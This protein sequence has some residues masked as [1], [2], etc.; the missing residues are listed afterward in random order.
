MTG[1]ANAIL[2]GASTL[3]RKAIRSPNY[4]TG[5]AGWSIN[6]DGSAE[7]NN[8]TIRG[9]L[10]VVTNNQGVFVYAGPPALGNLIVSIANAAGTDAQ[11]NTY[12]AG[13]EAQNGGIIEVTA[14]DGRFAQLSSSVLGGLGLLLQP[15]NETGHTWTRGILA[16][17][18]DTGTAKP[19][20]QLHGPFDSGSTLTQPRPILDMR[21]DDGTNAGTR[22]DVITDII[23]VSSS[24]NAAGCAL[25]LLGTLILGSAGNQLKIKEGANAAMG[26][27]TLAGGTATVSTTKITASSRVFLTAQST[28]GTP[29]ALRVS[30]RT[31]GTSFTITSSSGTDTSTV[32]WLIM[33]PA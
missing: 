3:I 29:G 32:G 11:G 28:G 15:P 4:V 30:A 19:I 5:S 20:L 7:F 31:A 17:D 6:K 2:G 9:S 12:I 22:F 16:G 8:L 14:A 10:Y 18:Y 23:N 27:A 21:G 1:F 26:T 25:T 33:E 24:N 13:V